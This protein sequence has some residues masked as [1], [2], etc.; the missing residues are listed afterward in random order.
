MKALA[1]FFGESCRPI[2]S[3][4]DDLNKKLCK[5]YNKRNL[6][7]CLLI[8]YSSRKIPILE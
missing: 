5:L 1:E 8:F 3:S 2:Q 4:D 6:C 7:H